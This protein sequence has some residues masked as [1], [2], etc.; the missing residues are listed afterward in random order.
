MVQLSFAGVG[1]NPI[2]NSLFSQPEIAVFL[3]R[4]DFGHLPCV[5]GHLMLEDCA[6]QS[7]QTAAESVLPGTC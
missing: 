1:A 3:L 6:N 5:S 4:T 2:T 7:V